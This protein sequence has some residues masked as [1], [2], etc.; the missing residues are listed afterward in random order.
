MVPILKNVWG[1]STAKNYHPV[2]FLSVVSK[3]FEKLVYDRIAY[4]PEKCGCFS[5]FQYGFR[6]SRS[7]ADLLTVVSGRIA[8]AFSMSGS[9]Q[10][11]APD[12]SKVFS[13]VWHAG[14]LHKLNSYGISGQI[15]G[16][17]SSFL[18][19]IWVRVFLGGKSLQEYPVYVGVPQVSILGPTFF[20]LYIN[21]FPGDVIC[22][23]L[24]YID[25]TTLYCN[26]YQASDL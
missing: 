24:V 13:R 9:T 21:D 1:K 20:L 15:F 18:S 11:V 19:N 14:L 5:Y 12:I 16:P 4:H 7:T 23:I 2:S 6:F 10:T 3:V 22:N 26:C 25:D 8:W 17:I